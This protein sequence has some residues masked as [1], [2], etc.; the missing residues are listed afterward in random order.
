M[1]IRNLKDLAWRLLDVFPYKLH[2]LIL[3]IYSKKTLPNLL[4]P[5]DYSEYIFRDNFFHNHDAHAYLADKYMVRDY[6]EKRGLSNSLT[7]LYGVWDDASKINFSELPEKFALKCN[8]SCAMNIIC[9]DKSELK[10]PSVVAQLNSWLKQE[11]S[12]FYEPHYRK[13]KPLI[14]CEEYLA[15]KFGNFPMDYKIHCVDGQ[16]IFIQCCFDRTETSVGKRAIYSTDWEDLHFVIEDY[17]YSNEQLPK[18]IGLEKMLKQ[19]AILSKGLDY[20]RVDFYDLDG[21]VVFG[22][23]TLTPMGGW[24][25]Y[26]KPEALRLM[27]DNIRDNLR[28]KQSDV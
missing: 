14:I 7:K 6:V 3:W 9:K 19:A 15:D 24:L 1:I 25:S 8:H 13:I 21:R 17:H 28:N 2:Y 18:P 4:N 5:R 12:I 23:M 10:I 27:G 16:P 20:V 11:H 22:E 26:F